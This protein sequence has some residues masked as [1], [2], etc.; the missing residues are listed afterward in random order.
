MSPE[1]AGIKAGPDTLNAAPSAESSTPLHPGPP[2]MTLLSVRGRR[3]RS[4]GAEGGDERRERLKKKHREIRERERRQLAASSCRITKR[5]FS[6]FKL[7]SAASACQVKNMQ[8]F[9]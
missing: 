2:L 9:M 3:R 7:F 4:C 5:K 8:L 1:R 6:P